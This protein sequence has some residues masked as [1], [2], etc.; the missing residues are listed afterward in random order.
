MQ[1][2][3]LHLCFL[4]FGR[5]GRLQKRFAPFCVIWGNAVLDPR[6]AA[7][8]PRPNSVEVTSPV[9][10]WGSLGA[11]PYHQSFSVQRTQ[12]QNPSLAPFG[13]PDGRAWS[14]TPF[15]FCSYCINCGVSFSPSSGSQSLGYQILFGC[16]MRLVERVHCE[17]Y[18]AGVNV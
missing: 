16:K 18:G 11:H 1:G 2:K 12:R 6:L 17:I 4:L 15:Q 10:D 3:L 5:V 8:C 14:K 13:I 7:V 9:R